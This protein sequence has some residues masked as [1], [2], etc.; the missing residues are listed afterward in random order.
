MRIFNLAGA[1]LLLSTPPCFAQNLS[2]DDILSR[3]SAQRDAFNEVRETG[4][5][6]TRNLELIIIDDLPVSAQD[7][8]PTLAATPDDQALEPLLMPTE[9]DIQIVAGN[10]PLVPPTEDA[11]ADVIQASGEPTTFGKL[12]VELQVNM[13][14]NFA[15]DSATID[16]DQRPNLDQLCVIMRD[17]D[18]NVF[19]IVGHTDTS[20]SDHYNQRLSSLRA[21][22]VA[23]Y[24]VSSCQID[25]ARIET[26]GL[27][28]QFP[29]NTSDTRADENRRV[30]FQALS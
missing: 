17:S 14:I 15:F 11:A 16:A 5:S 1:V 18:I 24:L 20:G 8:S 21:D 26:L 27:G 9:D 13:F 10:Q 4:Q 22:E 25:A 30:E 29:I 7:Q 6:Q 28:E 2:E 3:F 19:Q 12:P 23:R